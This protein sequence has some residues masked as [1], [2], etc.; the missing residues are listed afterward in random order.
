MQIHSHA[1]FTH[2][3]TCTYLGLFAWNFYY[4]VLQI[5]KATVLLYVDHYHA[6][7][8]G[9]YIRIHVL[10]CNRRSLLA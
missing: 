3:V 10:T 6:Y 2:A 8:C 9:K 5:Y 7:Y 1:V 4:L